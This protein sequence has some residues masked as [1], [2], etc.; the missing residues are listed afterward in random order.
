MWI[1]QNRIEKGVEQK[2]PVEGHRLFSGFARVLASH[3]PAETPRQVPLAK[4]LLRDRG[5]GLIDDGLERIGLMHGDVGQNLA[6]QFDTGLV[7][8]P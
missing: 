4:T 1:D 2:Q 8:A 6:V 7:H 3:R 5:F